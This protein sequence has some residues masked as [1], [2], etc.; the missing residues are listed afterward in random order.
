M[1]TSPSNSQ[2]SRKG[3]AGA[4]ASLVPGLHIHQSRLPKANSLHPFPHPILN[5]VSRTGT[6]G[7]CMRVWSNGYKGVDSHYP[8]L[9]PVQLFPPYSQINPFIPPAYGHQHSSI[10][11]HVPDV[12]HEQLQPAPAAMRV[13][14]FTDPAASNYERQNPPESKTPVHGLHSGRY[15]AEPCLVRHSVVVPQVFAGP[16]V[17]SM[18]TTGSYMPTF[19]PLNIGLPPTSMTSP[20]VNPDLIDPDQFREGVPWAGKR[21]VDRDD[22][23]EY[24]EQLPQQSL[25]PPSAHDE[26]ESSKMCGGLKGPG[27]RSLIREL[28]REERRE[29]VERYRAKRKKRNWK[30]KISY[31]C[32]RQVAQERLRIRGR[33]GTKEQVYSTLGIK[34]EDLEKNTII[35]ILAEAKNSSIVAS[36]NNV[37]IRNIQNLVN[38]SKNS[39]QTKKGL[40]DDSQVGNPIHDKIRTTE[41]Q[42]ADG[43]RNGRNE[44]IEVRIGELAR[45]SQVETIPRKTPNDSRVDF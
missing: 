18:I 7:E 14:D 37:K 19:I 29:K 25:D 38:I 10:S 32:R 35:K 17:P 2:R 13:I 40:R 23:S 4:N 15:V 6:R 22:E 42:V 28:T 11:P 26:P 8:T 41:M 31:A 9:L 44:V 39:T 5:S 27:K 45:S 36:I 1:L 33:F 34:A 20:V 21:S 12:T 30:K 43:S 3:K 16:L 24:S